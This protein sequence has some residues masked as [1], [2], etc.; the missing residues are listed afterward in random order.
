MLNN[1]R[2]I[3]ISTAGSRRSKQW[4]AST[5]WWS[6]LV[7]RLR[8]P[9]RSTE[10]L[11]EYL[12]LPKS[13]QDDLKD[14]GGFVAGS[15]QDGRRKANTVTERDVI[16]LDIDNVPS[17]GTVDILRRVDAL[18]CAYVIYSTRKHEETKPRLRVLLPISRTCTADEYE[19]LARKVSNIID[20]G[21]A[22]FDPS[23]FEVHRLMYWPSCCSD[24]QYVYQYGDKPFLDTDGVLRLYSDWHRVSE[25]AQVPGVQDTHQRLASKQGD[26]TEKPGVIGAFCRVYDIYRVMEELLSGTYIPCDIED[27]YTFVGGSTTGGAIIYDH[28]KFLFSH[29]ATDPAGGRLCNAFDLVRLHMFADKDDDAKPDTPINKMPSYV[30]MSEFAISDTSVASLLNTERYE[31][32]TEAFAKPLEVTDTNW[33]SKLAISPANGQPAKTIDNVLIILEND[34]LLKGKLAFDEFSNRGVTLGELPWDSQ[35]ERRPWGDPDDAGLLHYIEHVYNIQL[36][37]KRMFAAMIICSQR[38]KFNDL[39]DYLTALE[40]DGVKRLD[41]LFIDYLGAEDNV[42]TR[43]VARKSMAAAIARVMTPGVKYDSM[44]ILVGPQGIGKS[45]I[46]SKLGQR[47]FSDNLQTFEGKE[48]S[49]M[50]QGVWINEIGELNGLTRSETNAVKQFLSRTEDIFREPYGRRTGIYPRRCVFFG[51]TN[52]KEFLRDNTGE[53]R[54]WPVDVGLQPLTKNVHVHLQN[55]RSQI[56]AEAFVRWQ[57]G[58]FLDLEGEARKIWEQEVKAHK[59]IN[60]KEGIIREFIERPVPVGWDKRSIADRRLYWSGEFGRDGVETTKRDKVCAAEVWNECFNSETKYMKQSDTREINGILASIEG[61]HTSKNG[62][63]CGP[64]GLQRCFI[65][66]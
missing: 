54:F 16:T 39:R 33:I 1:D 5:M 26:P 23:T 15:L 8:T 21:M 30:A 49:E 28:G 36:A 2:Q 24:S 34:P 47:W 3:T 7:E 37:D 40:W 42:Y 48:A 12:R 53:R 43:A 44:P 6:E 22:I 19:P 11:A 61:W 25:W 59:V 58:E 56:W 41:T 57:L 55:E 14:V 51:T 20:P 27:R 29:H 38:H 31:K 65:K 45:T 62:V 10:G 46:L 66:D 64:Y 18:G 9:V 13:S 60:S 17:G 63:R 35:K 50:I 4:P 52:D 32:A